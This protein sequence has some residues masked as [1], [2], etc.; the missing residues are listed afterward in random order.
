MKGCFYL[1]LLGC[2]ISC[3][4][5]VLLFT[6]QPSN[7]SAGDSVHLAWKTRGVATMSFFQKKIY[8]PPD[9]VQA[10]EFILTATLGSKVSAPEIRQVVLSQQ[11][12]EVALTLTGL[13]GDS[14]IYF[15]PKGGA[16]QSFKVV[17][18][19]ILKGDPVTVLHAGE[20]CVLTPGVAVTCMQ[21][22]P[23]SGNWEVRVKMTA[24]QSVD[25][26]QIPGSYFLLANI[27]PK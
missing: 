2:C 13:S 26:H 3:Q 10:L 22:L 11:Q 21:G 24:A 1:I 6:A 9:S 14:A 4:P 7:V 12:D 8:V 15:T 16:S 17:S 20:T 18:L 27:T 25:H 5:K 19:S 23:Y